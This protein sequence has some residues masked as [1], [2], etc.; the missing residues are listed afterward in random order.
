[1]TRTSE[2]AKRPA[3]S[4]ALDRTVS[5]QLHRCLLL[6]LFEGQKAPD[7]VDAI[8]IPRSVWPVH[9]VRETDQLRDGLATRGLIRKETEREF[10]K[11]A[12]A[13]NRCDLRP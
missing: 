7:L 10:R 3:R 4:I 11:T 5:S 1:M 2:D 12:V 9:G 8:L 6:E 13:R